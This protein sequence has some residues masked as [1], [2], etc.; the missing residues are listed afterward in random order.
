MRKRE[1]RH[2]GEYSRWTGQMVP[3]MRMSEAGGEQGQ[4]P[5]CLTPRSSASNMWRAAE[6][7]GIALQ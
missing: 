4:L 5:R 1:R 2:G 6:R 7:G 3:S